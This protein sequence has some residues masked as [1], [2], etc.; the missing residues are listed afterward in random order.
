MPI[1]TVET[2]TTVD[3]LIADRYGKLPAPQRK[4]LRAAMLAANPHLD[5]T[6]AIKP[7]AVVILP[8][9]SGSASARGDVGTSPEMVEGI[10]AALSAYR[11]DLLQK[12]GAR[13]AE[14]EQSLHTLDSP[15]FMRAIGHV[16]EAGEFVDSTRQ[17]G[18]AEMDELEQ[19]RQFAG[20]DIE[21][22]IDELKGL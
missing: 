21:K 9:Q 12:A 22:L 8:A 1:T 15:E 20:A 17:D 3:K 10:V 5:H 2:A 19:I 14:L 11:D 7:G 18:K 4:E 6:T 13:T 16:P